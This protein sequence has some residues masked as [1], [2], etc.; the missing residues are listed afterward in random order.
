MKINEKE[1]KEFVE[2]EDAL[3]W[4]QRCIVGNITK[5]K[6]DKQR[7]GECNSLDIMQN[8][9]FVYHPE[10]LIEMQLMCLLT[11]FG[12]SNRL[13]WDTPYLIGMNHE[14]ANFIMVALMLEHVFSYIVAFY[15]SRD[16]EANGQIDINGVKRAPNELFLGN[17]Q[18]FIACIIIGFTINFFLLHEN[19]E[20]FQHEDQVLKHYWIIIDVAIIFLA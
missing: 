2:P 10:C 5:A 8:T 3:G 7:Q 16:I 4:V 19:R 20:V 15:R 13:N 17:I 11:V 6:L 14:P 1:L 12:Y 18:F 9:G